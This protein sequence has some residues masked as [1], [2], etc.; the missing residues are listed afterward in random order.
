[1]ADSLRPSDVAA[2]RFRELRKRR[3]LT[4]QQVVD[5]LRDLGMTELT[6]S[7]ITNLELGRRDGSGRRRM[8]LE[9]LIA[10]AYVLD[11]PP[12]ELLAPLG[13]D[14][15]VTILPGLEVG[16]YE[17]RNWL[18][19]NS[20]LGNRPTPDDPEGMRFWNIT[21]EP[22]RLYDQF[23]QASKTLHQADLEGRT[24]EKIGDPQRIQTTRTTYADALQ[25][26]AEALNRMHAAGME[27]PAYVPKWAADAIE[28]GFLNDQS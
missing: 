22:I 1:M 21:S 2:L 5:A 9:E 28:F 11:V 18:T 27:P 14:V 12:L 19:G 3:D 10:L 6:T 26:W 8:T 13:Q 16:P 4:V 25:A 7:V 15:T 24:A 20:R 23:A 17:L